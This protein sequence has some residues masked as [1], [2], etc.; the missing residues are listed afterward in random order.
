MTSNLQPLY[1]L[2][3]WVFMVQ[4]TTVC[5]RRLSCWRL[6]SFAQIQSLRFSEFPPHYFW[7]KECSLVWCPC[8]RFFVNDSSQG[9]RLWLWR[10][11]RFD[12][13]PGNG[14]DFLVHKVLRP[15]YTPWQCRNNRCCHKFHRFKWYLGAKV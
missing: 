9:H 12:F 7:T 13:N 3:H 15:T 2:I 1:M 11:G 8:V 14:D 5:H 4:R 6:I 10:F